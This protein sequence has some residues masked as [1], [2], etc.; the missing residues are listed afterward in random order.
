MKKVFSMLLVSS[1]M[2]LSAVFGFSQDI[3]FATF[4]D[5]PDLPVF[6][7]QVASYEEETGKDV[8]LLVIPYADWKTKMIMMLQGGTPPDVAR[9]TDV[10][11]LQDYAI[12]ITPYVKQ[13]TGMEPMDWLD[14]VTVYKSWFKTYSLEAGMI[15]AIPY[16]TDV[17]A[18]FYNKELFKDAGITVPTDGVWTIDQ[19]YDAMV[20]LKESGV[21]YPLVWDR[22]PSRFSWLLY[23]YGGGY[24]DETGTKIILDSKE[25]IE[26]M[27]FFLKIHDEN[28]MPKAVWISGDAPLKYFQNG[29]SAM[30]LSGTWMLPTFAEQLDFEW[31]AIPMP[32]KRE[33]Y[34]YSGGKLIV[35]LTEEGV[36]LAFYLTNK[37]NLADISSALY[38]LPDRSDMTEVTYDD[39]MVQEANIVAMN[40]LLNTS[41]AAKKRQDFDWYN[42]KTSPV[43][44]GNVS[45]IVNMV[46]S[47]LT[48]EQ[49]PEEAMK[50]L[51]D[52][53]R[54]EAGLK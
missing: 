46:V 14:T 3:T 9:E 31:G 40:D 6:Q 47:V 2:I 45:S 37:Q 41:P 44:Q 38:L 19:W 42:L 50:K 5:G 25:S 35:P 13:Y 12:D 16:T 18:L 8:E 32:V 29:L 23:T 20:K 36:E 15:P 52:Q 30:Y 17:F 51:A 49:T 48:H 10:V 33:R 11:Y 54:V 24:W 28:L 1:I 34:T 4:I 27:E 53:I 7:K 22:S 43:I 21:R 39:K 26:A